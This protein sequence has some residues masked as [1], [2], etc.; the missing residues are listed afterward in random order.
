MGMAATGV[1][2]AVGI[3][4]GARV[5]FVVVAIIVAV[6]VP[7]AVIFIF[8]L[9]LVFVC[10]C[11]IRR[12]MSSMDGKLPKGRDGGWRD[13]LV[14]SRYATGSWSRA[15]ERYGRHGW[16]L[17][18]ERLCRSVQQQQQQLE[19][20]PVCLSALSR[21]RHGGDLQGRSK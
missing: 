16:C 1:V 11:E 9:I 5:G 13:A 2:A 17:K 18:P 6:V 14:S 20:R 15:T 4:N 10:L 19:A 12:C 8:V 3:I 21:E 7:E